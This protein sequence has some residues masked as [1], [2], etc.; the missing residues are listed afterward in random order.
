MQKSGAYIIKDK[1]LEKEF[2]FSKAVKNPYSDKIEAKA[3]AEGLKDL[4]EGRISDGGEA[5]EKIRRK[6][7]I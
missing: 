2:D 3:V 4:R 7:G 5:V 6:Y 1:F